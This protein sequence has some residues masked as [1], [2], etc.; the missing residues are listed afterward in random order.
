MEHDHFH[1]YTDKLDDRF[2]GIMKRNVDM[3]SLKERTG[4]LRLYTRKE[5]IGKKENASYLGVRQ[6]SYRFSVSAGVEFTPAKM[7][8]TA[9]LVLYQNHEN[10]LRMEIIKTAFGRS[11]RTM[12]YIHG[13]EQVISELVLE[14]KGL[15]D[16]Q[17]RASEQKA[18]VWIAEGDN[19]KMAAKNIDLLPYTTEEAGGFVG[20]TVGMYASSN[21]TDSKNHAD[22][23]W[24]SCDKTE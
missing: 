12:A 1:F 13:K 16:I 8:E 17:L 2:L 11:F 4:F 18:E 23:A 19:L 20:C 10:H 14:Q 6:K 3:Y 5:V 7:N 15:L 24:F 22:Y 21:G 9:G